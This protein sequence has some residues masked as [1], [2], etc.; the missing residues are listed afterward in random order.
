M[1]DKDL[2]SLR[3]SLGN[4]IN[5]IEVRIANLGVT[6]GSLSVGAT[7]GFSFLSNMVSHIPKPKPP[8]FWTELEQREEALNQR[9][10]EAFRARTAM[11]EKWVSDLEEV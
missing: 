10:L 8:E 5:R 4:E 9:R 2:V 3:N 6:F 7:P 11:F 1:T